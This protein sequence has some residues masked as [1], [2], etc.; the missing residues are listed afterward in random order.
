M[1]DILSITPLPLP[2]HPDDKIFQIVDDEGNIMGEPYS[3]N[4]W[5]AMVESISGIN[6]ELLGKME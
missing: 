5:I 3:H 4:D 6:E 2:F 1:D